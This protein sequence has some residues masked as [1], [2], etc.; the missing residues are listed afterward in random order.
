[1]SRL[2]GWFVANPVAANLLMAMMVG[3]G[4][5]AGMSLRQE[6][7]PSVEMDVILVAVPYLGAAPEEV[8]E[9]VCLRVE[10][11]I[12]GTVG[13]DHVTSWAGEG[14]C[15]VFIELVHGTEVMGALADIQSSVFGISSFPIETEKPVVFHAAPSDEIITI[16]LSGA[17]ER[18]LKAHARRL[19]GGLRSL[20]EIS[21]VRLEF[22]R[23]D[24]ISVEVS[25]ESLRRY[26][27]R[28]DQV[29]D[30]LRRSSLDV[31][32]GTLKTPGGEV[33]LRSKAQART[34]R[35][36]ESVVLRT[37]ADGTAVRVRDVARVVDGFV[38]DDR[39]L[40]FEGKPAV[41]L[42]LL[43]SG[44]QD[45]AEIAGAFHDYLDRARAQL[46]EGVE[47][48]VIEDESEDLRSRLGTLARTT[49]SG[50][51]LVLAALGLVLRF[52]L[53]IWVALGIPIALLGAL[54]LFPMAGYTFSLMAIIGFLLVLGIV[55]DDAIVVGE[56]VYAHEAA[57]ES[58]ETAA[59]R[60]TA[61]VAVPVIFGVLTTVAAFT[62]LLFVTGVMGQMFQVLGGTVILCLLASLVEA[63]LILPAHL[64]HRGKR[65]ARW[66][67][68]QSRW[69]R[70]QDRTSGAV[71]DFVLRKYRP[72]LERA[73]EW[74]YAVF[75]F[76]VGAML[77][78]GALIRA[79]WIDLQFFAGSPGDSVYATVVLPSGTAQERTETVAAQ[80]EAAAQ[81]TRREFDGD[82]P[83][84]ERGV[85]FVL[86][87][88]GSTLERFGGPMDSLSGSHVAQVVVELTPPDGRNFTSEQFADRWRERVGEI[89]DARELSFEQWGMSL[90]H[91]VGLNLSAPDPD[92]LD[93]AVA[94][95]RAELATF[96]GVSEIGDTSER[97]KR[98]VRLRL[99]PEAE[100]LGLRQRD[101]AQQVRAAF[102][103]AEAQRV[104][105]GDEDVRVMVRYPRAERRSLADLEEMR[106][107]TPDGVQIPFSAV[108]EAVPGIG[109]STIT[110][111]DGRRVVTVSADVDRSIVTPEEI[112]RSL[113]VSVMPQLEARYPGLAWGLEG[114]QFQRTI[115]M[116]GLG[117]AFT[118]AMLAV[119][120]LL[121][122]PLRSYLQPAVVMVAIPFGLLGALIGHL[123]IGRD[124]DFMSLLGVV[125][126]SGVV[127]N[128]SLVLV[129]FVNR[130]RNEGL[131][132]IQ[133]VRNAGLA[134]FRPIFLTSLTTF[135][136]LLPLIFVESEA[137][138]FARPIAISLAFG[139]AFATLITLFLVPCAYLI[140]EDL[141]GF[142][143]RGGR[144]PVS[145]EE[146]RAPARTG[147]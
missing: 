107:R 14:R 132:L 57:G 58:P 123:V 95:L 36:F 71:E 113:R 80:L 119:Y 78:G 100:M 101:L 130:R 69:S 144:T 54:A 39:R 3:T 117:T 104:P 118:V 89:P 99:R 121:A 90:G 21:Q 4:L 8:E 33:L 134:R 116:R 17:D 81:A 97:G 62:P 46:P 44:T 20:P 120:V 86:R 24:E 143:E 40:R 125:A 9:G 93:S 127:V 66:T 73:L 49:T 98:E 122:I 74:R 126:L 87:A 105:R 76:A 41:L 22:V 53:A 140:L 75:A 102:Y 83:P 106:V 59:V 38:E 61:E 111:L 91:P 79:G 19:R 85:R 2:V 82:A 51:L 145:G 84:D 142:S 103:G 47:L 30:A 7:F 96:D 34:A 23:E 109:Y 12:D 67:L 27:L 138:F 48:H 35:E 135:L 37:R 31:P 18:A 50:F 11:A 43:R 129:D 10:E 108:A 28:F 72:W 136:G 110:R 88:V 52:R 42:E 1:M 92:M 146:G 147:P 131:D 112:V 32:G 6:E 141:R 70:L 63:K 94:E 15:T 25:E 68:R 65:K 55:V 124:P 60:G 64:A 137:T 139:V 16:L 114:E 45:T 5:L 128:D 13:I 26:G 29:V 56:R 115:A 77:L 133:A